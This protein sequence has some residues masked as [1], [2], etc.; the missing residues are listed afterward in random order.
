[1]A[2]PPR[3]GKS[4]FAQP[5]AVDHFSA[6]TEREA[7]S[8]RDA[9][10]ELSSANDELSSVNDELSSVNEELR[11]DNDKLHM[12]NLE[13]ATV[14]L[15]FQH[16]IEELTVLTDDMENLLRCTEV[17]VLFLDKRLRIRKVTP[18][19]SRF[20]LLSDSYLGRPISD[21]EHRLEYPELLAD[22]ELVARSATRIEREIRDRSGTW[23]LIRVLPYRSRSQVGGA[24]LS[25]VD[26]SLLEEARQ[27]LRS[28]ESRFRGTFEN[29]AVGIAHVGLDGSWLRVNQR[30]CEICGYSPAEML[31]RNFQQMTHPDDLDIDRTLMAELLAG[32][33]NSYSLQKRYIRKDGEAVWINLTVSLQRDDHGTPLNFISVVQ[34]ITPRKQFET[35]LTSAIE[36]RDRFIATLS[37]ELRNP[38]AA[39]LHATRLMQRTSP[40]KKISRPQQ[41]ILRQSEHI[42][43]MLD[44]LLDVA[45]VTQNKIQLRF[46]TLNLHELVSE[47]LDAVQ[48]LIEESEHE[49]VVSLAA[50]PLLADVD[51]T[52]I[53]QVLENLLTNAAK[54][55]PPGGSIRLSTRKRGLQGV[56]SVSDNGIG[57]SEELLPQVFDMF[58]QANE[59]RS[60]SR[61]GM[62]LGLTL[63]KSLV[64]LHGGQVTAASGGLGKGSRFEVSLPLASNS[65]TESRQRFAPTVAVSRK[66]RILIVEDEADAREMLAALLRLD[67]H[68]VETAEDGEKGLA[69]LL[70]YR[71]EV[72]LIDINLPGLNGLELARQVRALAELPQVYLV[73]LT[74]YGRESDRREA[75]E[76]GFDEH[77]VKPVRPDALNRAIQ[78]AR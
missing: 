45:R 60:Q 48:P 56:I 51:R 3:R 65:S 75:E 10:E 24:V 25:L 17:A 59:D 77:L 46:E 6:K 78:N 22:L 33:T 16:K 43:R 30:L 19:I 50:E 72:A 44:D 37:H 63:V 76:A 5:D 41:V 42:A 28:S 69:A 58:V 1:M 70:Q 54:Y 23:F 67:G 68:R 32:L 15:E 21:F 35:Q 11:H 27:E 34:D 14:N 53:L 52:R 7:S 13:L 55:T 47:A 2:S 38:L 49:L 40:G 20:F 73:A 9:N 29:A 57:M 64:E 12:V 39:V 18:G 31:E 26:L 66:R 8:L 71:P 36:Q 74:G 4:R 62:G 61:G